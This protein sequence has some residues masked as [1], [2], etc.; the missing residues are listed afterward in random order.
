[1]GLFEAFATSVRSFLKANRGFLAALTAVLLA[2]MFVVAAHAAR[3]Q[4]FGYTTDHYVVETDVSPA[5]AQLVGAHMETIHR[6]EYARR[7]KDYGEVEERFKVAVFRTEEGYLDV[8]PPEVRGSTGVFVAHGSLLA[9]HC[10]GRTVEEVLRTLYH[11]GFHQFM[12]LAVSPRCPIWLNEGLAEYF[13]EATW[14]GQSFTTGQIPTVRLHTVQQAL[15]DGSYIRLGDL[16]ELD[17]DQWLQNV[18]TDARRASLHY[19]QSWSIAHFLIH[20]HD[21][22]YANLLDQFLQDLAHGKP[23][24]R[25]FRDNFGT[26]L[27]AFENAWGN[28][29]LS[30]SPSPKFRCRDNL[31][32]LLMLARLVYKDPREMDSLRD[33]RRQTVQIQRYRWRLT[34]PTGEELSW[35]QT[36]QV[37]MLFQC[38]FRQE[39]HPISYVLVRH[40]ETGMPMLVCVHHP[41]VIVKCYYGQSAGGPKVIVEEQVRETVDDNLWQAI[42][43]AASRMEQ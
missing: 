25:A 24:E 39:D 37:A 6:E 29:I 41:G 28:Y 9:A 14:N 8:V 33:L 5:F 18:Q 3:E 21:G 10:E 2:G 12:Y 4:M 22:R 1:M 13:S 7:F 35:D 23:E 31:Q 26:D 42:E 40:L 32:A 11:E 19:C 36:E 20:A 16:F 38:P 17:T 43:A 30:L 27:A 34:R 15:R